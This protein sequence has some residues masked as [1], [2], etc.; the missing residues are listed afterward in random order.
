[1]PNKSNKLLITSI[2]SIF[3]LLTISLTS[4]LFISFPDSDLSFN[5]NAK[6]DDDPIKTIYFISQSWWNVD[7]ANTYV[8]EFNSGSGTDNG[9]WPGNPSTHV[10]DFNDGRKLWKFNLDT[11]KFDYF[12]FSRRSSAGDDGN[13]QTSDLAYEVGINCYNLG[14]E[15]WYN[16]SYPASTTKGTWTWNDEENN[17]GYF[18]QIN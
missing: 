17:D 6:P 12:V 10:M 8:Y 13:A 18:T 15:C 11:D 1:M 16:G 3:S 4:S 14:S 5:M 9:S 2:I 7:A